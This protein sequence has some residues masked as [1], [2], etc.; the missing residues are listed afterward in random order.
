MM[1]SSVGEEM[2]VNMQ[3]HLP[4]SRSPAKR[5]LPRSADRNRNRER[6]E[7]LRN[8]CVTQ[9]TDLYS[10]R[11]ALHAT[12]LTTAARA[13]GVVT[14]RQSFQHLRFTHVSSATNDSRGSSSGVPG[15][16][17][18]RTGR[19][20]VLRQ[21]LKL[22]RTELQLSIP[23]DPAF[24]THRCID[25]LPR[26]PELGDPMAKWADPW[27]PLGD[28]VASTFIHF[29]KLPDLATEGALCAGCNRA[30]PDCIGRFSGLRR[31]GV[32]GGGNL[33]TARAP[34]EVAIPVLMDSREGKQQLTP[35]TD[36]WAGH[37]SILAANHGG[38]GPA[39]RPRGGRGGVEGSSTDYKCSR[40]TGCVS[41]HVRSDGH[42]DK[43][44]SIRNTTELQV[45]TLVTRGALARAA[46]SRFDLP[47][48]TWHTSPTQDLQRPAGMMGTGCQPRP[49]VKQIVI[50]HAGK[51][52]RQGEMCLGKENLGK[53][54]HFDVIK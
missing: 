8:T 16:P 1:D 29:H 10:G 48:R 35:I 37:P 43:R 4:G 41:E 9:K 46:C 23:L 20:Y 21:S 42:T 12:V 38:P 18:R 22:I 5:R 14:S 52:G 25:Y 26:L 27:A 39:G 17:R 47:S 51:A 3:L 2:P 6:L 32:S 24:G 50:L 45:Q 7:P 13:A 28:R 40:Y 53:H 33:S 19:S 54:V 49:D 15:A 36:R 34:L 30:L 44:H 11:A 31:S